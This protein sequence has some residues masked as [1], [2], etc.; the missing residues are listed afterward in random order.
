MVPDLDAKLTPEEFA[1]LREIGKGTMQRIIII[2]H[3]HKAKLL[4]LG[5]IEQRLGGQTLTNLGSFRIAKGS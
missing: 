1:S 2:P 5:F 3:A 4:H